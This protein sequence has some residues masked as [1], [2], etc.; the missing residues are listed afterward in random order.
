MEDQAPG[1]RK[2]TQKPKTI[3]EQ[4][5]DAEARHSAADKAERNREYFRRHWQKFKQTKARIYGTVSKAEYDEIAERAIAQGRY[6]QRKDG[7]LQANVFEQL[8]AE[9]RAYNA[10][11][12]LPS[13]AVEAMIINAIRCSWSS[14]R[15]VTCCSNE[16]VLVLVTTSNRISGRTPYI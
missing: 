4:I 2:Q 3:A 7:T 14:V 8:I 16:G 1:S 10:Q 12:Y 5:A 9:A 13:K 11:T 6:R 15:R